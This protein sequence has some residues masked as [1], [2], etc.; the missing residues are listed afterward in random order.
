MPE[1]TIQH[2]TNVIENEW[3]GDS[4]T[5]CVSAVLGSRR[6]FSLYQLVPHF[7]RFCLRL[8]GGPFMCW[9]SSQT[10]SDE[11]WSVSLKV[12]HSSQTSANATVGFSFTGL[13]NDF[14]LA[15]TQCAVIYWL[16]DAGWDFCNP[17]GVVTGTCAAQGSTRKDDERLT[18]RTRPFP[19]DSGEKDSAQVF[20]HW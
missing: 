13:K 20:W 4:V 8:C 19:L 10:D 12:W 5:S 3:G 14:S 9:T 2:Q 16:P 7:R 17:A 6:I 11:C 1:Q 18:C 15:I